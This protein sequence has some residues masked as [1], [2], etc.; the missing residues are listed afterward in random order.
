VDALAELAEFQI[1]VSITEAAQAVARSDTDSRLV[2]RLVF[3]RRLVVARSRRAVD[4]GVD[5]V[6][7]HELLLRAVRCATGAGTEVGVSDRDCAVSALIVHSLAD[8]LA[9]NIGRCPHT[10]QRKEDGDK[11]LNKGAQLG[12]TNRVIVED[13]ENYCQELLVRC[14]RR[15]EKRRKTYRE[16]S[17]SDNP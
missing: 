1:L 13:S 11:S 12:A 3:G 2:T 14:R 17:A 16:W 9:L 5:G 8:I 15:N 6:I 10:A 4:E 7:I